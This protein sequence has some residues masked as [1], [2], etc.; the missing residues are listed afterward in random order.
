MV[1]LLFQLILSKLNFTVKLV[2][3]KLLIRFEGFGLSNFIEFSFIFFI[4][5]LASI[6]NPIKLWNF[7]LRSHSEMKFIVVLLLGS[8][9]DSIFGVF[10]YEYIFADGL[11]SNLKF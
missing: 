11:V 8:S 6:S 2:R 3:F 4:F 10:A 7:F 5:I 1:N 9:I